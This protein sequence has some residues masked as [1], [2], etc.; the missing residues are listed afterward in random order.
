LAPGIK[1]LH[2][3]GVIDARLAA[4]AEALQKARNLSAH[5]SGEKVSK[6]DAQ[7]LLD[8]ASAICEYVFVLTR[9]F[10]AYMKRQSVSP[11]EAPAEIDDE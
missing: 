4:W 3:K 9:Q 5:A 7:D 8:F 10:E 11:V 2:A 1:E 6:Q